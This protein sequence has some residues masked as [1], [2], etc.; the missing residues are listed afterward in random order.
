MPDRLG[1]A[2]A[3]SE[4]SRHHLH[5][6]R[7]DCDY[8][9][10]GATAIG[11]R[12]AMRLHRREAHPKKPK[13]DE[14]TETP[15]ESD[16][17]RARRIVEEIRE[18]T[19]KLIENSSLG[20]P[21]AEELASRVSDEAVAEVLRRAHERPPAEEDYE[22]A[23]EN[24]D[25]EEIMSGLEDD[26]L[27]DSIAKGVQG[28]DLP[29]GLTCALAELRDSVDDTDIPVPNTARVERGE[30]VLPPRN[31]RT[32]SDMSAHEE[33]ARL[34]A[35]GDDTSALGAVQQL[36]QTLADAQASV[37]NALGEGHSRIGDALAPFQT[38]RDQA[39]Q[40]QGVIA[41]AYE[42]LKGIAGQ[43]G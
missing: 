20:T 27:M 6:P 9:A 42:N 29:D 26:A 3:N 33:A 43:I 13:E 14:V 17:E 18:R 16:D 10:H 36:M 22:A 39:E 7:P 12:L 15:E 40:L 38:A 11:V 8:V 30:N 31:E 4:P 5:C 19:R 32:T 35:I 41:A 34:R 25:A 28:D 2:L 24:A 37:S 1:D 23:W 21:G